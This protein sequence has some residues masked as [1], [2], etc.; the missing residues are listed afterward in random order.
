M[1]M[2]ETIKTIPCTK[3]GKDAEMFVKTTLYE[4]RSA[5]LWD[6]PEYDSRDTYEISCPHCGKH[7][8]GYNSSESAIGNW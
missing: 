6:P 1:N 8:G 3:C 7:I 4:S 5:T 2:T